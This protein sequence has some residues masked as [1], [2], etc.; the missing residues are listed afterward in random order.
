MNQHQALQWIAEVFEEPA[1]RVAAETERKDIAGWD[2][3]GTLSLIAAL[4]EKFDIQLDEQEI[5]AMARVEDI[6][7][8]LR[9]AGALAEA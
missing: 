7:A 8:V 4:D 5:E 2:S 9:R 3:L 6:L 1:A